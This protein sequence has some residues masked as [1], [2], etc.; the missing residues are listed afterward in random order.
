MKKSQTNNGDPRHDG[1]NPYIVFGAVGIILLLVSWILFIYNNGVYKE[2]WAGIVLNLGAS[3]LVVVIVE[4]IW[5][6]HGGDPITRAIASL[7]SAITELGEMRSAGITSVK[8]K[9]RELES[10]DY[11]DLWCRLLKNA[12]EVDLMA[13]TLS[14]QFGGEK[15][16]MTAIE[17]A[18]SLNLCRIKVLT[19]RPYT[20]TITPD[21]VALR[22]IEEENLIPEGRGAKARFMGSL[23]QTRQQFDTIRNKF[24][25]DSERKECLKL[26]ETE[27]ATMYMNI[28]RIDDR[29]WVS[30]YLSSVKGGDRPAFEIAG[31]QTPLFQLFYKEFEHMWNHAKPS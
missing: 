10:S 22:R 6:F 12:T 3:V 13:F 5:K 8:S 14:S 19:F 16:I 17:H 31:T 21:S 28:I 24:S 7:Y 23:E 30:P 2:P 11:V 29:M 26:A 4:S 27:G 9:R 25:T 20:E 1:I 15:D 18:I